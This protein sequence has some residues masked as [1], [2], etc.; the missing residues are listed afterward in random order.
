MI[1]KLVALFLLLICASAI[2]QTVNSTERQ[3]RSNVYNESFVQCLNYLKNGE[4]KLPDSIYIES[5]Y[6]LTNRLIPRIGK[7]RLIILPDS[8]LAK[9]VKKADKAVIVY[10]L[11]PLA[12]QNKKFNITIIPFGVRYDKELKEIR[13][14]NSGGYL[15][16]FDFEKGY[17]KFNRIIYNGI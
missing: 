4:V 12:Y 5:D 9:R 13:Y 7:T 8:T 6:K 11:F 3:D 17:F 1:R 14:T 16:V 10:R 2:G 15:I